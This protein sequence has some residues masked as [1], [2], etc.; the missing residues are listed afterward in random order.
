M[1]IL[2]SKQVQEA[3][4][5]LKEQGTIIC[6]N[7]PA[8]P[9]PEIMFAFST[10][11]GEHFYFL[12][13]RELFGRKKSWQAKW[14]QKL[15]CYS[16]ERG[17]ADVNAF[18]VTKLLLEEKKKIVIFPEGEISF[19]NDFLMPMENG[20][21]HI[22]LSA[23]NEMREDGRT[24]H[25]VILPI[26]V[27][28]WLNGDL[29][30]QIRTALS[31]IESILAVD[32]V[33]KQ[34][35]RLRLAKCF[36]AAISHLE[37]DNKYH[38]V[39]KT[40]WDCRLRELRESIILQA[41][42]FAGIRFSVELPQSQRLHLLRNY[43]FQKKL[44]NEKSLPQ[45]KEE[46][47]AIKDAQHHYGQLLIATSLLAI[48]D[49]S[50]HDQMTQEE[51]VELINLLS[52]QTINRQLIKLPQTV[53]I[54]VSEVID[55]EKYLVLYKDNKRNAVQMLKDELSRRLS[56]RLVDLASEYTSVIIE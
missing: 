12:T 34:S 2:V 16:V 22:A 10:I 33:E 8:L 4:I 41:E 28:Y 54:E 17:A 56:S 50:F 32:R 18:R 23:L 24:D 3:F 11:V 25:I 45:T 7:H 13:A 9:D 37:M 19:Q 49:H 30:N 38:P 6:P 46:S 26:V 21:E 43:F 35:T 51:A 52:R 5:K 14:Y 1:H 47:A 29:R 36:D 53:M 40:N 44:P 27:K 55:I 48:G 42:R 39:N 15:G 31:K 20:P